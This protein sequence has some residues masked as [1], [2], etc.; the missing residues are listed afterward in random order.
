MTVR[1]CDQGTAAISR[2][3]HGG[4]AISSMEGSNQHHRTRLDAAPHAPPPPV[5][6]A[7][8]APARSS[9]ASEL[10]CSPVK[11]PLYLP[12]AT[13]IGSRITGAVLKQAKAFIDPLI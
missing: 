6:F 11:L 4:A 1:P 2:E 7:G 10:V 12:R 8:R 9:T 13:R 3:D 5:S